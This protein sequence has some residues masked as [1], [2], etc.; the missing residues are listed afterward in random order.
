VR[1]VARFT[2]TKVQEPYLDGVKY[3]AMPPM[4]RFRDMDQLSGGEKTI[5]ALA[6]LF[7]IHSYHPSPFF[8]L[9]EVDAALDNA[10]VAKVAKYIRNNARPGFQF[11]VISLKSSLFVQSEALVGIYRDQ[12]ENSSKC[13][14]LNVSSLLCARLISS[15]LSILVNYL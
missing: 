6:L 14:T 10:N 4:K 9:D 12:E 11:V 15:S 13:L 1:F 7:A 3:N 5:A 2:L 8:V